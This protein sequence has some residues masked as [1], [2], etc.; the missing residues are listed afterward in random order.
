MLKNLLSIYTE[1]ILQKR[2]ERLCHIT[3]NDPEKRTH[4]QQNAR[5]WILSGRRT[6]VYQSLAYR[7]PVYIGEPLPAY[8]HE[9]KMRAV[10]GY[11]S[12]QVQEA[13]KDNKSR[14]IISAPTFTKHGWLTALHTWGVNLESIDTD[15]YRRFVQHDTLR[16]TQYARTVQRMC[17]GLGYTAAELGIKSLHMPFIGLGAFLSALRKS[18]DLAC[19]FAAFGI[20]LHHTAS[21]FPELQINVYMQ[22]EPDFPVATRNK[23]KNL[24]FVRGSLFNLKPPFQGQALVNAWD[25]HSFVGNGG[26]F[27]ASVDGFWVSGRRNP[28]KNT[29]FLHHPYLIPQLLNRRNWRRVPKCDFEISN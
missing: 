22:R 9:Q 20:S 19:C 13:H 27:D 15:D 7:Y 11:S 28:L 24:R 3:W 16:R 5:L 29:S 23:P 18:E 6:K 14:Y 4:I 26:L 17:Y 8:W 25:S 1:P 2:V 21:R 12:R 10:L